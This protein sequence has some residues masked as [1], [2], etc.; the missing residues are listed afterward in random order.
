VK[1]ALARNA[2]V[3]RAVVLAVVVWTGFAIFQPGFAT[4]NNTYSIVQGLTFVGLAAVAFG[5][6]M[7]A[8]ELDLAVPATA[9]V[10]GV[11][12]L[13]HTDTVW[14]ALL[15]GALVGLVI[16]TLQGVLVLVIGLHSV[17]LTL[18][19]AAALIGV[20][21]ELTNTSTVVSKNLETADAIQHQLFI[22]SPGSIIAIVLMAVIGLVLGRT[23]LGTEIRGIGGGRTEAIAAG[24]PLWRPL[25][26]TFVISGTLSGVLGVLVSLGVGSVSATSFDNLLLPAVTAALVGGVA[27]QGGRGTVFGI[28]VGA[29]TLRFVNSGMS[30][31]GRP[32]FEV[33]LAIAV[34]L[35]VVVIIDLGADRWAAVRR[36]RTRRPALLP[37]Q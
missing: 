14:T 30:L 13:Q 19:T 18:G 15:V 16:G 3:T 12:A 20:A 29:L 31:A 22:F 5:T 9:T 26:A 17:V 7:I 32:F 4:V 36:I 27:L 6:T 1:S 33:S 10:A 28:G 35:L 25:T 11:I 23:M 21:L 24:V 37:P 8:G 34:L 2:A